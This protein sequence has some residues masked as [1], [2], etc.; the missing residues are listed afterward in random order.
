MKDLATVS[1]VM[2]ISAAHWL[3]QHKGKC[4]HLHGHNYVFVVEVSGEVNPDTGMVIDFG[5]LKRIMN[6]TIGIWD[7]CLLTHW[8][9]HLIDEMYDRYFDVLDLVG[10]SDIT[11]VVP[12]G[13]YT[14]AE[15]LSKIAFDMLRDR[16][17]PLVTHGFLSV[18]VNE[19]SDSGAR[20]T[21]HIQ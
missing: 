10:M 4:Q 20:T 19:T 1:K 11:R 2:E 17:R 8:D 12:L 15:N 7:H 13:I 6:E 3:P 5:D 18:A 14:T 9:P 16:L 21:G